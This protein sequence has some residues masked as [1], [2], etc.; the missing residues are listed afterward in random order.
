[1]SLEWIDVKVALPPEE[2]LR[3]S[4]AVFVTDGTL[5]A[6]RAYDYFRKEWIGDAARFGYVWDVCF[7]AKIGP[8][9]ETQWTRRV[10]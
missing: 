7:W 9:P 6:V 8:L 1:M 5:V 4:A 10:E 2:R 3:S